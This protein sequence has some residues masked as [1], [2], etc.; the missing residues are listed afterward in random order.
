MAVIT[1]LGG[2]E[3]A[4]TD[5][6]VT[7]FR[8][9]R[10]LGTDHQVQ[11]ALPDA[12]AAVV[13]ATSPYMVGLGGS[14]VE[15]VRK[16]QADL[17]AAWTSTFESTAAGFPDVVARFEHRTLLTERAAAQAG[18]LADVLVFP[19]PAGRSGHSLSPAFEAVLFNERL[20]VVL[21]GT[22]PVDGGCVAIAWDGSA[23][24]A[25]AVRFHTPLIRAAQ[26]V[27]IL[28]NPEDLR[29]GDQGPASSV[30]AL[31]AWL[32]DRGVSAEA[33]DVSGDVGKALLSVCSEQGAD[34][35]IAGAF[36]HSRAGEFLF[37]GASRSFL[38]AETA[39]ALAMAH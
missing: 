9:A 18:V 26:R 5:A 12:A 30:D 8:L 24:A 38:H 16:A 13:Y 22:Q 25:R 15:Q 4:D 39:P 27:I 14:A 11:S 2:A 17:V 23:Q 37:G 29:D 19:R 21:A 7:G 34:V 33:A 3:Q 32:S 6:L 31:K 36:G 35:L 10:A 20:P 28:Q 1:M